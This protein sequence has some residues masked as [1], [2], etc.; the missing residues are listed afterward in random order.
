MFF[1]FFFFFAKNSSFENY[2]PKFNLIKQEKEKQN[3]K[4]SSDYSETYNQSFSFSELKDN[5]SKAH[6]SSPGPD[7][8][9]Y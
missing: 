5:L 2:S 8:I 7:D 6:D 1:F 9:N 3:L 4:F